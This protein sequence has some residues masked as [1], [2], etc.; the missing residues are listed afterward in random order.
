MMALRKR[1]DRLEGEAVALPAN[2]RRW[3][4]Q[5]LT[6]A[7]TVEADRLNALPACGSARLEVERLWEL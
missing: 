3:L 4:G 5:S 2:V 1:L 6:P 7:E